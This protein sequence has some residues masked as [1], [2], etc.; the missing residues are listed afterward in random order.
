MKYTSTILAAV[1]IANA[2]PAQPVCSLVVE[3][4]TGTGIWVP[5]AD[6]TSWAAWSSSTSSTPAVKTSSSV[7]PTWSA[8]TSST[9]AVKTSS[10]SSTPAA[11]TSSSVDPT[12]SAWTS[13][14]ASTSAA[15]TTTKVAS[16]TWTK[17]TTSAAQT[18]STSKVETTT[19]VATTTT[20]TTTTTT[21]TPKATAT[22]PASSGTT[23]EA[24]GSCECSY[25]INCGTKTTPTQDTK[26]WERAPELIDTLEEC[27]AICDENSA[28][29]AVLYVDDPSAASYDYK[30]C[31]QTSGLPQPNGAGT[32]QISYKGA[33][34]GTCSANYSKA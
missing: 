10:T 28:C 13:S 3:V 19:S 26:F 6:P 31:W 17:P 27:I 11:T 12:W 5:K 15:A 23:F 34:S 18:S 32:A 7:D 2:A 21:E 20:A 16:T 29:T 8:W 30:H 22:C 9:P 4:V 33:C 25:N 24:S 14:G 1:A